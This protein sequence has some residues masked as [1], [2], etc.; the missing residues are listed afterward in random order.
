MIT[1]FYSYKGGVGRTFL[2]LETAAALA[3]KGRSV[4]YWDL[5]LEAPG[6]A[7]NPSLSSLPAPTQGTLDLV[8]SV[9]ATGRFP[10]QWLSEAL[11]S[12][13]NSASPDAPVRG[14][15]SFL[16]PGVLDATY[17]AR[18]AAIN[19]A[20]FFAS[21]PDP[22]TG[23]PVGPGLA[24]LHRVLRELHD[25]HGINHVI[26]DARTGLTELAAHCLLHLP[27][28]VVMVTN[29]TDQ[30]L[31]PIADLSRAIAAQQPNDQA[32]RIALHRVVTFVPTDEQLDDEGRAS[33]DGLLAQARVDLPSLRQVAL[34]PTW[35]VDGR[36]PSLSGRTPPDD[37]ASL[38]DEIERRRV[39]LDVGAQADQVDED[40]QI[41]KARGRDSAER[42]KAF[43][44]EVAELFELLGY[45]VTVGYKTGDMQFD[46]R[47]T[48]VNEHPPRS[49]LVECKQ[50]KD[51]ISQVVVRDH[52]RKVLS[53]ERVDKRRYEAVVVAQRFADNAHAAA[54]SEF[55]TLYTPRQLARSLLNLDALVRSSFARWEGTKDALLY[56][57]ADCA[58][59]E[60]GTRVRLSLDDEVDNWLATPGEP[61]LALLGEFG[62]GKS[63]FSRRLAATLAER[64]RESPSER[65]APILL[66]LRT[67]GS[68]VGTIESMVTAQYQQI[69]GQGLMLDAFRRAN[70]DGN[71]VLIVDGFD[72]MLAYT[73]PRQLLSNLRSI[74]DTGV[75]HAKLIITGRTNYFRDRPEASEAIVGESANM[76]TSAASREMYDELRG[77]Q[78]R[79]RYLQM[80][81][82]TQMNHYLQQALPNTWRAVGQLLATNAALG[83]LAQRP[84]LLNL[85]R[86]SFPRL[87]DHES[88]TITLNDIYEAYAAAWVDT[89]RNKQRFLGDHRAEVLDDLARALWDAPGATLH[90]RD[91]ANRVSVM[92]AQSSV[93]LQQLDAEIRT[94]GFLERDAVGNYRFAHRSFLEF[95]VAASIRRGAE[96]N[97]PHA[98]ALQGR[99]TDDVIDFLAPLSDQVAE[100][101]ATTLL[102]P[103]SPAAAVNAFLILDRSG[104]VIPPQSDLR[105]CDLSGLSFAPPT[106]TADNAKAKRKP[107]ALTQANFD[108]A[109][110]TDAQL[111]M[112]SMD[113]CTMRN[114]VAVRADFTELN[115]PGLVAQGARFDG[116]SLRRARLAGADFSGASFVAAQFGGTDV[117][118]VAAEPSVWHRAA[119]RFSGIAEDSSSSAE[120]GSLRATVQ[121]DLR[122]G[123]LSAVFSPDGNSLATGCGDDIVRLWNPNSGKLNTTL[124]GHTH[125]VTSVA[126][127]PDGHTLATASTD[128]TVR[129]WNPTNGQHLTTLQGHTDRKGYTDEV[130][131]VAYSP[132][133]HT[134]ATASID[135]TVRLWNPTTGQ[136]L[137]TLQGHTGEVWSVAFSPDGHTL[138]TSSADRTVRLWNP[139]TGQLLATLKGHTDV[140]TSVAYSPD[141]RT[142]STASTDRTVQLW[143]ATTGQRHTSLEA[144]TAGVLSV[145]FSPDGHTVASGSDD[146]TVRLWNPTTGQLIATLEGHT[147]E[148]WSVAFS[149]D[150]HTLVSSSDD[151]TTRLWNPTTG[152]NVATLVASGPWSAAIDSQQRVSGTP[153]S[154]HALV[155]WVDQSDLNAYEAQDVP[156]LVVDQLDLN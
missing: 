140:V 137:T 126:Y 96:Q 109:D 22:A 94:A 12:L 86:E 36:V 5:D 93:D 61:I 59:T 18:F 41:R 136:H 8:S 146:D 156:E 57:A 111:P 50:Y 88:G 112:A 80:F 144:H 47:M 128:H 98:L 71:L 43:E 149:P 38:A 116:A 102:D 89:D 148:V 73:E 23:R 16:L 104:R 10:D 155:R 108:G 79:I 90:W 83:D 28:S 2:A 39:E 64:F 48:K 14:S 113:R 68:T 7:R 46:L 115:A 119:I 87:Q 78:A 139:I 106:D 31:S 99:L 84:F 25:K 6:V 97:D 129:L 107:L 123:V 132:D 77:R 4:V 13:P 124:K 130:L 27:N 11:V 127:S 120:G 131:S 17:P 60:D 122:A 92:F 134:L 121:S 19:W 24:V 58:T 69:T 151:S 9:L 135:H 30:S 145:A 15:L 29:L 75:G 40:R 110:F 147:G 49:I 62:T 142:L 33:R 154:I 91:L 150:G 1:T 32:R 37:V 143:D 118:Q 54:E 105:N 21:S 34:D 66:D 85:M 100:L 95:F 101:C 74:L 67:M 53:A 114:A 20:K 81:N 117:A 82:D 133:G 141:G 70:A 63:T 76:L 153:D 3:A 55:V 72:E 125:A 51:A 52:A 42:G 103:I 152:E 56:V 138:A 26:I 65:R 35:L 44:V 45:E